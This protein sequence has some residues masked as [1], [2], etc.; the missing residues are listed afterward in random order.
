MNLR[1]LTV[2]SSFTQ[3]LP[4]SLIVPSS[5]LELGK[6][7]GQGKVAILFLSQSMR[8]LG[9]FINVCNS[10]SYFHMIFV[11]QVNLELFTKD[12]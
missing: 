7:I 10:T 9:I 4:K 8:M 12:I 6:T 11:L 2:Q 5:N 1:Y 3:N